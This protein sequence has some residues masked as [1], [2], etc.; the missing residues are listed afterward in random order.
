M[1]NILLE[2]AGFDWFL[3]SSVIILLSFSLT[4]LYSFA[5]KGVS[6]RF[7]KQLI[8]LGLGIVAMV[9][10]SYLD[11]RWWQSLSVPFYI[12]SVILLVLVLLFGTIIRGARGWFSVA[13]G[14]NFQPVGLMEVSL[15]LLLSHFFSSAHRMRYYA[16]TVFISFLIMFVPVALVLL[17]PDLGSAMVLVA[18][19]LIFVLFSRVRRNVFI[20]I[21]T[22][23][24]FLAAL[25]WLFLLA[26]Y[27]KERIKTFLNPGRDGF[28]VGYNVRQSVIAIGSGG[29]LGRG[30]GLG[31]QSQLNFLPEKSTD[32]IFA[33]LGE[34]LGFVGALFILLTFLFLFWR[35]YL[36]S[37]K[38]RDDFSYLLAT[39]IM[40]LVGIKFAVNIGMNLGLMPVAGLPLPFLSYGGSALVS[41]MISIGLAQSIAIRQA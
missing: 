39:G 37:Q 33:A 17:Q 30:L 5:G 36:I 18:L 3:F 6:D 14:I 23:A 34:E 9:L 19:W 40:A 38:A 21:T 27:Q 11:Y 2:R 20:L 29:L 4:G 41:S 7:I 13:G 15:T 26:P 8:F 16:Q 22:C 24:L 35:L 31:T 25:S 1:R 12:F 28:G 10:F 32:F